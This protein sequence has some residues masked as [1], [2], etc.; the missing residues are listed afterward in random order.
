L[1]PVRLT[2]VAVELAA[3]ALTIVIVTL[4]LGSA[5]VLMTVWPFTE[6]AQGELRCEGKG[7]VIIRIA[8]K[9]YAVNGMASSEYPPIQRVWNRTTYPDANID[10]LIVDGLTLCDWQ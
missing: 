5:T 6:M 8:G 3:D 4:I 1:K 2:R 10:K 9:D 7:A